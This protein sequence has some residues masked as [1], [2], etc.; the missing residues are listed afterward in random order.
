[1]RMFALGDSDFTVADP[2]E[3]VRGRTVRDVDGDEIGKVDD[4]I[5][6]DQEERVRFLRVATGGFLGIGEDTFLVPVDAIDSIDGD[7]VH[8]RESGEKV[9]GGPRYDPDIAPDESDFDFGGVYGYYGY[10]P[11]WGAGYVYPG[12]P[13]YRR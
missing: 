4:L 2:A 12:Y 1:M 3:D 7:H 9:A 8:I 6:D 10:S 13:Y 5:V 11:F